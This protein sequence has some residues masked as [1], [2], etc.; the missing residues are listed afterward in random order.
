MRYFT[1]VTSRNKR[2]APRNTASIKKT[3]SAT[4]R[5]VDINNLPWIGTRTF[6]VTMPGLWSYALEG[7]MQTM[8]TNPQ[9]QVLCSI[10]A[11]TMWMKRGPYCT[12][13]RYSTQQLKWL[14]DIICGLLPL[15]FLD[16]NIF[17]LYIYIPYPFKIIYVV[18][19]ACYLQPFCLAVSPRIA[20]ALCQSFRQRY[21]TRYELD[22]ARIRGHGKHSWNE[23]K[24]RTAI[25]DSIATTLTD[26][27]HSLSSDT[28]QEDM[29]KVRLSELNVAKIL[30]KF[31]YGTKR[32]ISFSSLGN[33]SCQLW[34]VGT[35]TMNQ[36]ISK[37][38]PPKFCRN[39]LVEKPKSPPRTCYLKRSCQ[40]SSI[41][42]S[43]CRT[44][45]S[46][47]RVES[48]LPSLFMCASSWFHLA[49]SC[50]FHIV[51][52]KEDQAKCN[53]F[54]LLLYINWI[55]HWL[56]PTKYFFLQKTGITDLQN[57]HLDFLTPSF[58]LHH[59]LI[60]HQWQE[61]HDPFPSAPEDSTPSTQVSTNLPSLF[62]GFV[63]RHNVL[64]SMQCEYFLVHVCSLRQQPLPLPHK[65]RE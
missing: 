8:S 56:Q 35:Q 26:C 64:Q 32:S 28:K 22:V 15:L 65:K 60:A 10:L 6:H 24:V 55:L 54:L 63:R 50:S 31:L 42:C 43:I 62:F 19:L 21:S 52:Y 17:H 7:L 61:Q 16:C 3:R 33:R 23:V 25:R 48:V 11:S 29:S 40:T 37:P 49:H 39:L 13:V 1:Y 18:F 34:K 14:A 44:S 58:C 59:S 45:W 9:L 20:V 38:W 27:S 12:R 46:W 5:L 4:L 47:R 2:R 36:W 51:W 57:K 53:S 30:T 41:K